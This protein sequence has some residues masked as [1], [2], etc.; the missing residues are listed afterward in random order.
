MAG[1]SDVAIVGHL[2]RAEHDRPS[3]LLEELVPFEDSAI[4]AQCGDEG[5]GKHGVGAG[6]VLDGFDAA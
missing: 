5:G 4:A 2:V 1:F 3:N 6:A